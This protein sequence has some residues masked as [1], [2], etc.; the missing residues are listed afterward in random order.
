MNQRTSQL[1]HGSPRTGAH[2]SWRTGAHHRWSTVLREPE[3]IS[4]GARFSENRS[5][6]KLE[7]R[8]TSQMEHGSPRTGAHLSWST[9]LR[10]PEHGSPRTGAHLSWRTGEHLSG[11]P[12][13]ISVHLFCVLHVLHV[14]RTYSTC[15]QPGHSEGESLGMGGEKRLGRKGPPQFGDQWGSLTSKSVW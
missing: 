10:E 11:E 3:H 6:P 4:V 12:E 8:S 15:S 5:T 7:N 13:K 2:L 14:L 1:E 9:V